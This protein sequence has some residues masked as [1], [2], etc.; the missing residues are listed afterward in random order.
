M[1]IPFIDLK[2]QYES[3]KERMD[4]GL[5]SAVANFQFA[6]GKEVFEFE[7]KFSKI[8]G[9]KYCINTGNGTDSLFLALK[10]VDIKA[11]DEVITPAWSWISSS[12]TV[13]ACGARP[14]F[15]DVDSRSYT[16]D[17]DAVKKKI[18]TKTKAVIAVHLYGQGAPA[19]DL[20]NLC[21]AHGLT[22]IEDCA[23]GHLTED[24]HKVAGSVGHLAAFS[25]YPT[26]N[27][28][29]Y[30]DAGCITTSDPVLTEKVRRLAN[31]GAL[32]K[33]DHLM[34][35]FNSRMDTLQ[36][37]VLLI[38]L[39]YLEDWT[40]KRI[41]NALLYNEGLKDIPEITVPFVRPSSRHTYHIYAVR[42][43]LRDELSAYLLEHGIQTMI[44]YPQALTN[45]PAYRYLDLDPNDYPIANQLEKDILSLPIYPELEE[46][47]IGYICEKIRSFY[48]K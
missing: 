34:E 28:G 47:Q 33:D 36:A 7:E 11:G 41:K 27:L 24:N 38:K 44:H 37:A 15:A 4:A 6:K 10:A 18:N 32:R 46:N 40:V 2:A 13:S 22:L 17:V 31:H 12:E 21:N 45:L 43:A 20:K 23:Q 35:G 8:V 19:E 16:I 5:L 39:P 14:V 29:A 1:N 48:K 3:F 9:S 26:K 30:G 25:F 42:A